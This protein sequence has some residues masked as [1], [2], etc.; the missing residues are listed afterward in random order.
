MKCLNIR[1][2]EETLD[3][4]VKSLDL[5]HFRSRAVPMQAFTDFKSPENVLSQFK[6][7]IVK[8]RYSD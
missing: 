2:N 7:L 8:F 6:L 1:L 4:S 3:N 5:F